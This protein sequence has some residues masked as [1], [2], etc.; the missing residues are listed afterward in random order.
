MSVAEPA[1]LR[2]QV[3]AGRESRST[4]LTFAH[5]PKSTTL[6]SAGYDD[7][8]P[9]DTVPR[10]QLAARVASLLAYPDAGDIDSP[11]TTIQRRQLIQK[12]RFLRRIYEEWY[13][14]IAETIPS[15]SRP[16][17]ELGSGAGFMSDYVE[18]LITSDILDLPG[19][20][21]I[22]DA[23][24]GLPCDDQS[25]RAIAM[26]N[27]LH[28]LSDV[29]LFFAEATRCL[30]AGGAISMIEPWVTPWSRFVYRT[31]HHEPFEPD[32]A[33][34]R[35]QSGGPLSGANGALPWLVFV[36]DRPR[37]DQGF[38]AL[39]LQTINPIMPIRYLLSGGV[40]MRALVPS[41]SFA[42]LRVA[43]RSLGLAGQSSAMFAHI[44]IT[45]R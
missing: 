12:K 38:P 25:L 3:P 2:S 32:V 35:F 41:W 4:C 1:S 44:V 26:V 29:E 20:S 17:L 28:H 30:E 40:S 18:N 39:E 16:A 31:L 8:Q 14:A 36:R 7:C 13:L 33:S 45:R 23:S 11:E 22:I 5:S 27:T 21:R 6:G 9:E 19:V 43:E 37:F 34:W 15:G 42:P 24:A 10:S